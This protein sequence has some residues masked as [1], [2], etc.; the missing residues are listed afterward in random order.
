MMFVVPRNIHMNRM[1]MLLSVAFNINSSCCL[2]AVPHLICNALNIVRSYNFSPITKVYVE[3]QKDF[4]NPVSEEIRYANS[5]DHLGG[6]VFVWWLQRW[7]HVSSY[8]IVK[9]I[10]DTRLAI[11]ER[12]R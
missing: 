11:F 12:N 4:E 6:A 5:E 2:K 10:S 3:R 1:V 7:L 8:L 9:T